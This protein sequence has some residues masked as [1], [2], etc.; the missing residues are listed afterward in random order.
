MSS[1]RPIRTK[2]EII[3][4]ELFDTNPSLRMHQGLTCLRGL[5]QRKVLRSH[6]EVMLFS[7]S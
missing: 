1:R 3:N 5:Y 4:A 2:P 6:E 7:R